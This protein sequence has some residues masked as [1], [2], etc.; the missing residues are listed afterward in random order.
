MPTVDSQPQPPGFGRVRPPDWRHVELYPAEQ[1]RAAVREVLV[2]PGPD[3]VGR[4][5]LAYR[6][7]Q[8]QT[9]RCVDFGMCTAAGADELANEGQRVEFRPGYLYRWAERHDGLPDEGGTTVRAGMDYRRRLG[10]V[11]VTRGAGRRKITENRWLTNMDQV[12]GVLARQ[13]VPI[14]VA[15]LGGMMEPD[16]AGRIHL[17]GQ[18]VGGHFTTL[19]GLN[20]PEHYAEIAQTWGAGWWRE[21]PTEDESWNARIDLA[22]LERL[23]FAMDGEAVM[24]TDKLEVAFR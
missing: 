6:Y 1:V 11:P 7:N 2:P 21:A 24:V 9:P 22:E 3:F 17:T 23:L 12:L 10:M 13:V 8:G 14:G 20:M 15:W 19:F 16:T 5:E 4:H 18:E